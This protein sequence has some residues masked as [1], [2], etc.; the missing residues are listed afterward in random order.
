MPNSVSTSVKVAVDGVASGPRVAALA[1]D[2]ALGAHSVERRARVD[3]HV[4]EL[5]PWVQYWGLATYGCGV[6]FYI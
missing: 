2:A 1:P 6:V 3:H 5:R 4:L